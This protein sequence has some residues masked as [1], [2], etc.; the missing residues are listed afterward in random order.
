MVAFPP[1]P[2]TSMGLWVD[3]AESFKAMGLKL[4]VYSTLSE[5][6]WGGGQRSAGQEKVSDAGVNSRDVY[7]EGWEKG[8]REEE[9]TAKHQS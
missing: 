4:G 5:P 3:R 9:T 8:I 6:V 2:R 1:G 7:R